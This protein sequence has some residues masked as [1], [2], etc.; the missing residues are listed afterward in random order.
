MNV[1]LVHIIWTILIF[2]IGY[3]GII[4]ESWIKINKTAIAIF[5][6]VIC[7]M[8]FFQGAGMHLVERLSIFYEQVSEV[9]EIVLFLLGAMT[10]VELI[11][12]HQGFKVITDKITTRSKKKLLWIIGFV[13]F[14]MSSVLDNL[15]T[16]IVMVSLLRKMISDRH[17]RMVFGSAVVIAANAGGAWTPIGDVTTTMLWI[18]GQITTLSV[19]KSL[20]FPS[21]IALIVSLIFQTYMLKG[22]LPSLPHHSYHGS[23]QPSAK[24][25][26]GFGIASLV[27][28][29]I[30]CAF[31]QLP[32]FMGILFGL[33]F[34]WF[35]TDWIHRHYEDRHHLRVPHALA[36]IDITGIL[37]VMGIVLAISALNQSGI[38]SILTTF[39]GKSGLGFEVIALLVGGISAVID[40]VPLVSAL[41]KM[42]DISIFLPDSKLWQMIA[43]CAGTGG[44]IFIIGSTAGVALMGLEKIDFVWYFRKMSLSALAGY[45]AGFIAYL[46]F[47][48]WIF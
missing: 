29:P 31:T 46:A 16:T 15:T 41:M 45:I 27:F 2:I 13:A 38:L 11:D 3:I 7:W 33:A 48:Q 47:Y 42:Y 34:V 1:P 12:S 4:F 5:I 44:S 36:R 26:F 39:V 40:N 20:F 18:N 9:S 10:I 14:F 21:L 6:A 43:Y 37:F 24:I 28:V 22:Q 19:M 17:D 30:F 32:P 25:I 35:I 8:I 23:V